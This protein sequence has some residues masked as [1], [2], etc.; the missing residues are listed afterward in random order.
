MTMQSADPSPCPFGLRGAGL[1]QTSHPVP[2]K[3]YPPFGGD[4]RCA[5]NRGPIARDAI[6]VAANSTI[7]ARS[8]IR[9]SLFRERANASGACR[10]P[11]VRL[12]G[13]A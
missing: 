2:G 13:V 10:S 7:R 5:A 6:P 1:A 12:I 3:S 8:R 9:A 4:A 11:A